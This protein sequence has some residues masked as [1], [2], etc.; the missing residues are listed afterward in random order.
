MKNAK[1]FLRWPLCLLLAIGLLWTTA[2]AS[3]TKTP[4]SNALSLGSR[5]ETQNLPSGVTFT[6]DENPDFSFK[7]A[8]FQ[9]GIQG[10]TFMSSQPNNPTI[11]SITINTGTGPIIAGSAANIHVTITGENLNGLSLYAYLDNGTGMK[12]SRTLFVNNLAKIALAASDLSVP[13]NHYRVVVEYND[14][15]LAFAPMEVVPLPDYFFQ[16]FCHFNAT[17]NLIFSLSAPLQSVTNTT[18]N[19]VSVS[20]SLSPDM[21]SIIF[22]K[23]YM[24]IP[25]GANIQFKIQ[26]QGY[27]PSY[28]F[29]LSRVFS[30]GQID[31]YTVIEGQ[32]FYL[33]VNANV[34]SPADTVQVFYDPTKLS[35]LDAA[36]QTPEAN[37]TKE[38][39]S[40]LEIT[41]CQPGILLFQALRPGNVYT[42][43]STLLK[44][45]SQITGETEI[46]IKTLE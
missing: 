32:E 4:D 3:L 6:C 43:V 21:Q 38:V 18:I 24:D 26:F 35:L 46:L 11:T 7:A 1:K 17:G 40:D 12:V 15:E 22:N 36:A 42:A 23:S 9:L 39:L 41:Y 33:S 27:Y 45:Q 30:R 44:W 8:T 5:L 2:V 10:N 16:P 20:A 37:I 25:E 19:G 28:S 29:G 34:Q 14:E 13:G 31:N